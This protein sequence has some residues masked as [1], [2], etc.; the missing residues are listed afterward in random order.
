MTGR[1]Y[2]VRRG[3]RPSDAALWIACLLP[4]A[5]ALSLTWIVWSEGAPEPPRMHG[6]ARVEGRS[7]RAVGWFG[8]LEDER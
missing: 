5:L 8:P 6:E 2:I 3:T 1:V 4:L 7:D